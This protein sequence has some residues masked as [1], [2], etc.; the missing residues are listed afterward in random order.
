MPVNNGDIGMCVKHL[1][2]GLYDVGGKQSTVNPADDIS[3]THP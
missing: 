1:D 3:L 2:Y